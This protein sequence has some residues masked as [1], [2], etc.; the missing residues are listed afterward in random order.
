M[1]ARN[2]RNVQRWR[3]VGTSTAGES[4]VQ[5]AT[6]DVVPRNAVSMKETYV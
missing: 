5:I 6:K 3:I 4:V 2:G 1:T